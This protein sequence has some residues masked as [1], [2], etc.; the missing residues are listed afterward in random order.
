M[1]IDSTS[2]VNCTPFDVNLYN[3]ADYN[4]LLHTYPA[5][6]KP[7]HAIFVHKPVSSDDGKITYKWFTTEVDYLPEPKPNTYYIVYKKIA[8][9]FPERKDLVFPGTPKTVVCIAD[10][11]VVNCVN[12]SRIDD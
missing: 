3:A 7:V 11:I 6:K 8:Q 1:T 9:A 12:F 2:F 4:Q 10:G 5:S